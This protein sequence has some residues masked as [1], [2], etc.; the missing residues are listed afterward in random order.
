MQAGGCADRSPY[1]PTHCVS[2]AHFRGGF[3]PASS[4]P[5]HTHT[6]HPPPHDTPRPQRAVLQ[7]AKGGS[8]LEAGDVKGLAATMGGAWVA[9]FKL[10]SSN[11][12]GAAC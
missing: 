2:S 7:L 5:F 9:D 3:R 12:G 6:P 4:P 8:Q 1:R 11:V 10:A